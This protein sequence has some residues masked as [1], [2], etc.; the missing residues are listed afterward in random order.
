MLVMKA[1]FMMCWHDIEVALIKIYRLYFTKHRY[2]FAIIC[3]EKQDGSFFL[4]K[5]DK[6]RTL[7]Q[8]LYYKMLQFC[9][10]L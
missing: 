7:G 10:A 9:F 5:V 2:F 4:K 6:E 3:H 1:V 8:R